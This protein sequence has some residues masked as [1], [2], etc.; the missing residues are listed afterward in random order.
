MEDVAQKA[1]DTVSLRTKSPGVDFQLE[2][3]VIF[4]HA[5][6]TARNQPLPIA[7]VDL[8]EYAQFVL[9]LFDA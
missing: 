8:E 5:D 6:H 2:L 9:I 3:A 4:I 7:V 1:R